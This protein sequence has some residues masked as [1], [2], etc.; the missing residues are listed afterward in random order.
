MARLPFFVPHH[1]CRDNNN[2]DDNDNNND[3]NN[4]NKCSFVL[5]NVGYSDS[6]TNSIC[7]CTDIAASQLTAHR[8]SAAYVSACVRT[9]VQ[10]VHERTNQRTNMHHAPR[11]THHAR[12][13]IVRTDNSQFLTNVCNVVVRWPRSWLQIQPRTT[14]TAYDEMVLFRSSWQVASLP[15]RPTAECEV[16]TCMSWKKHILVRTLR[17]LP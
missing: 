16:H 10:C 7:L 17:V 13:R 1:Y 14:S 15:E 2:D 6:N 12:I 3:N 5:S 9:Y 4:N 11:P 8:R